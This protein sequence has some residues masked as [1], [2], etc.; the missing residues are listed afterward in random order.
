MVTG[1]AGAVGS[2]V[3]QLAKA[4]GLTVVGLAGDEAKCDWLK[5]LG[6]DHAV[7]Y[8]SANFADAL[9]QIAP[10]GYN[11]Y[12]DNVGGEI[13][14]TI[15]KL[16]AEFGRIAICGAIS[17]YNGTEPFK[18]PAFESW[19][20]FKQL[21]MEGFLV[22]R[23]ADRYTEGIENLYKLVESGKLQYQETITDGFEQMPQ[24]LISLLRG[25]NTGKAIVK[26]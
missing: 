3:G 4:D 7:N 18:V 2:I 21:K 22:G 10:K 14:V 25:G 23:F 16:M 5:S 8:K 12:F 19:L 15:R 26:V 24:A 1:A 11:I 13:S 6:F 9:R 17:T 20:A